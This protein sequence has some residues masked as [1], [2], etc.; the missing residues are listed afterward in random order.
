M[1]LLVF[2]AMTKILDFGVG[3]SHVGY[4]GGF[5]MVRGRSKRRMFWWLCTVNELCFSRIACLE[6]FG[7]VAF[8]PFGIKPSDERPAWRRAGCYNSPEESLMSE[9]GGPVS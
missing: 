9:L 7:F 6:V 5:L 2:S 8:A 1:A 4:F 3:S